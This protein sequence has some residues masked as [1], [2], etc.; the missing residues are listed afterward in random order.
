MQRADG[1]FGAL[2]IREP[3][4]EL[5]QSIR[6]TYDVDSIN[7]VMIMQDWDHKT[8]VSGFNSFHH[9][10]GD[11]KPPNILINSRG[12]YFE[13][14]FER[15]IEVSSTSTTKATTLDEKERTLSKPAKKTYSVVGTRQKRELTYRDAIHASHMTPFEVFKVQKGIRYRFRSINSGFL[16]CPLEISV[17]NHTL[18]VLAS[19]GRYFEP[20]EVDSLVSYAGERFDFVINANQP[21]GNYWMRIRG[22]MDCDERF[23]KAHQGAIIRYNGAEEE[24]PT[25]PLT[26]D[27]HRGGFQMNSLNRGPGHI[28]SVSVVELTSL[29]PDTPELLR[30]NADYKFFVYYDFYDKDFPQFNNPALYSIQSMSKHSNK[31]FGPQLNHISM[32]MPSTPLQIARERNDE[33]KFCN[34]SSLAARNINCRH[35]FCE[36]SHVIQ[37]PLNATV[38]IILIDEGQKYDANHPFHLHGHDFRVVAMERVQATGV[39]VEQIQKLDEMGMIK[40]RLA[41]APIKDTVTVPDGGYT[42]IRFLANNP[43]FWL[44]HCHIEFHV[45]VGMG[46]VFK[47]GDYHQMPPLPRNFP[48]CSS[49]KPMSHEH[50]AEEK[51]ST[52]QPEFHSSANRMLVESFL[53]ISI[54]STFIY[55]FVF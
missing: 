2:I 48:T 35:D 27:F 6:D 54:C 17:D 11:N 36:C 31:F 38:E 7:H 55:S 18:N 49:Y 24:E 13:P 25:A 20:V 12:K 41:G 33:T 1:A 3:K 53:L 34:S 50:V 42:V 23:T 19:D 22:L 10:I 28:D 4:S 47:V 26:Y 9:S 14:M 21:I 37:V 5:P 29:D 15:D 39:T 30:E 45:E 8:G 46:L 51:P 52:P 43:G 40:R 32:R 16:N 44:M